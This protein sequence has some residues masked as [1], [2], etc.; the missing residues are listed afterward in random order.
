MVKAKD[1]LKVKSAVIKYKELLDNESDPVKRLDLI[2]KLKEQQYNLMDVEIQLGKIDIELYRDNG[3]TKKI[4]IDR[5]IHNLTQKQLVIK[6]GIGTTSLY[7]KLKESR[8]VFENQFN[9]NE[10]I[11]ALE[12][13]IELRC[14]ENRR[15][16]ETIKEKRFR[17]EL[18]KN[19]NRKENDYE[20][21]I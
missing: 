9:P 19:I 13:E 14:E 11:K 21:E 5:Y 3:L 12:D 4:F 16:K 8:K 7:E 2:I 17:L 6:Y 20:G 15:F 18:L 10:Y 1:I